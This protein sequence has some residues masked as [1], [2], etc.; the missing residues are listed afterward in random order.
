MVT[1][2]ILESIK[3][4]LGLTEE[5]TVFDPDIIMHINSVFTVLTQIGVGPKNG[6]MIT[7]KTATWEDFLGDSPLFSAAKTY[8]YMRVKL[9][10]DSQSM[11]GTLVE[12]FKSQINE[13]ECRLN[14]TAETI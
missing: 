4:L 10:F 8:T 1:E 9:L 7:D 13:F 11:S 14:M 5:Y 2:S 12:V 3:K 6:F